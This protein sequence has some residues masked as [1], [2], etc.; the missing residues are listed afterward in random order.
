M[1]ANQPQPENTSV[2]T[3]T[4]PTGG[5][6][7]QLTFRPQPDLK[8]AF[9]AKDC[10]LIEI[11]T[12][13]KAYIIYMNSAGTP[14]PREAVYSHLR[15]YVDPWWLVDLGWRGLEIKSDI[16]QFSKVMDNTAR[17]HFPIHALRMNIFSSTQK[18][19]TMSFFER[20]RGKHKNGRLVYF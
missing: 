14:I 17:V 4:R 8:P 18:G 13:M 3:E 7:T 6:K 19:D 9:L 12:F 1:G 20:N 15:V 5:A 16:S 2:I 10:S 11:T